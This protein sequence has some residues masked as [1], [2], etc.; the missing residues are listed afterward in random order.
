MLLRLAL[1]LFSE[2]AITQWHVDSFRIM[3]S[4]NRRTKGSAFG[5]APASATLI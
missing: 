2:P 4:N 5:R 1:Y 3:A